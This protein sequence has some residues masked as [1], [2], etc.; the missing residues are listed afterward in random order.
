MI[1]D[2]GQL[3][4]MA[5]DRAELYGKPHLRARYTR[6][7]SYEALQQRC[8]VCGRRAGSC[9]HV[10]RRSWGR[11][12]RLV[13]PNGTWDL[14]SPLFALCGSGTTGCHGGFHDG[15]LRAEWSWRSSVYEEAWWSGELLREYGPH[16]PGLY[17]YGY[18]LITDRYG[19]EMIRE[20]M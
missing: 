13:T 17:E 19:N 5:K 18:W 2:A 8:A 9:H 10:A 14:R 6:G 20:A 3:R 12:F 11:S 16:H 1:L 7:G 4:G 15:G